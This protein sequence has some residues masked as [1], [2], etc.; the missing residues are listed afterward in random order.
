MRRMALPWS[1]N[2]DITGPIYI[3]SI[4]SGSYRTGPIFENHISCLKQLAVSKT[5]DAALFY[6]TSW[7]QS[8][9]LVI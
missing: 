9:R 5:V 6:I 4:C 1:I 7:M 2:W 3:P 8:S